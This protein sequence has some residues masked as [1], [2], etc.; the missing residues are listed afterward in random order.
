MRLEKDASLETFHTKNERELRIK[1][2]RYGTVFFCAWA[3][4]YLLRGTDGLRNLSENMRLLK[5][6]LLTPETQKTSKNCKQKHKITPICSEAAGFCVAFLL[7]GTFKIQNL[8]FSS[9][10]A[11]IFRVYVLFLVESYS[12][13]VF[14]KKSKFLAKN[15]F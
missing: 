6:H 8:Q 9:V 2:S 14:Q 3:P 7:C 11:E 4:R 10:W 15:D 13:F 5:T 1:H 12:V